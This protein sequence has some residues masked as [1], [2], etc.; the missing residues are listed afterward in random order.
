MAVT[1]GMTT[2]PDS[3]V[4]QAIGQVV[5][6]GLA[7]LDEQRRVVWVNAEATHLLGVPEAALVGHPWPY[8]LAW[9][10]GGPG[11]L[12]LD[13]PGLQRVLQYRAAWA[14][15]GGATRVVV[16]I[17]DDT[18]IRRRQQRRLAAV[19][20]AASSVADAGR[21]SATLD[22][23]ARAVFESTG[24]AAVQILTLHGEERRLRMMGEAGFFNVEGFSDRLEQCRRRGAELKML[25]AADRCAPVVVLNRKPHIM[26]DPAWE[27]LHAIMG[28]VDWDSFVAM[29]LLAR[30]LCVGVLNAFFT[31]GADPG[32]A[33][34]EFLA[35]VADQAALA[36]DYAGLLAASRDEVRRE[37]RQRLARDLH[38]SVVQRVFSMRMQSTALRARIGQREPSVVADLGPIA[39]E[40]I[41]LSKTALADLRDLIFE[42]R[43][44][45]LADV[46]LLE[47]LR[48]HAAS[49]EARTGMRIRI[50]APASMGEL[51]TEVQEDLYRIV[52]EALQNVV[53]HAEA[54]TAW[55]RFRSLGPAGDGLEIDVRDDGRGDGGRGDGGRGDGGRGDD[56]P[57]PPA[58]GVGLGMGMATMKERA[59]RWGG[60]LDAGPLSDGGFRVRA[61]FPRLGAV[62]G[63]RIEA[64]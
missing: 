15:V 9:I 6:G 47:V 2:L 45:E 62:Y 63:K 53:K 52:Q 4:V 27:P 20:R 38:D 10:G 56:R 28:A 59:A 44:A 21:L 57:G 26:S 55:V 13:G 29:P 1:V 5:A 37:E 43:P 24:L 22:A 16:S 40:L 42:L 31:P 36:V 35:A 48:V 23:V 19:A 14:D 7:V 32:P 64:A 12:G 30:D 54:G 60:H 11:W 58:S 3:S 51:P 61:T 8:D 33:D 39:D 17:T 41:D 50:E 18:E 25:E 34:L 49:T 46:G